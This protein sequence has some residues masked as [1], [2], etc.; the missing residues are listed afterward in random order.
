[1]NDYNCVL[2]GQILQQLQETLSDIKDTVSDIRVEVAGTTSQLK[3]MNGSVAR[4]TA[5]VNDQESWLKRLQSALDTAKGLGT[6]AKQW[7]IAIV[8]LSNALVGA[9]TYIISK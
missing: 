9:I 5:Q 7:L 8:F 6:G 4:V 3:A 1:M 2:H